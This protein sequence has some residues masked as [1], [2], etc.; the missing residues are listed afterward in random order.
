MEGYYNIVNCIFIPLVNIHSI[1]GTCHMKV[2]ESTRN[3][4]QSVCKIKG[5]IFV[6]FM[7][8]IKT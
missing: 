5:T 3:K 4:I 2:K 6:V 1:L 7:T 8:V